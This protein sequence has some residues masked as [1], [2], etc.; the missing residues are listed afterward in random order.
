MRQIQYQQQQ[1]NSKNTWGLGVL[2]VNWCPSLI[3][4]SLQ[5]ELEEQSHQDS[6]SMPI[7]W[8]NRVDSETGTVELSI[9][10]ALAK[11]E[12]IASLRTSSSSSQGIIVYIGDS[13]TDLL[14]IL[15]ADIGILFGGSSSTIALAEQYGVAIKPLAERNGFMVDSANTNEPIIWVADCWSEIEALMKGDDSSTWFR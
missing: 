11:Q 1:D 10:G 4:A 14:A 12:K 6:S 3:A 5:L 7:I 8:S 15:E 13:S 9:P 2:S